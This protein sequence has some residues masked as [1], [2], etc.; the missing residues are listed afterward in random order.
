LNG[1]LNRLLETNLAQLDAYILETDTGDVNTTGSTGRFKA[2]TND[3]EIIEGILVILP[4][5]TTSATLT[6]GDAPGLTLPI[7]D[8]VTL[9]SPLSWVVKGET[10]KL[11]YAPA[12][13]TAGSFVAIWGK[14]AP[15]LVPGVL[16]P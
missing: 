9:L 13:A 2:Q 15:A 6:L 5:G 7:Q 4:V 10:R 3:V 14:A 8:T 16:H 11:V 12:N 1:L